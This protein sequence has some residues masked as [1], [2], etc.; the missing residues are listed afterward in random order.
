MIAAATR[1]RFSIGTTVSVQMGVTTCLLVNLPSVKFMALTRL[2]NVLVIVSLLACLFARVFVLRER[3]SIGRTRQVFLCAFGLL[4]Y[5][6]LLSGLIGARAVADWTEVGRILSLLVAVPVVLTAIRPSDVRVFLI[7]QAGWSVGVALWQMTYGFTVRGDIGLHYLNLGVGIAGGLVVLG[8][9]AIFDRRL[10]LRLLSVIGMLI[11]FGGLLRLYGRAP[12]FF[13]SFVVVLFAVASSVV[14]GS[15]LSRVARLAVVASIVTIGVVQGIGYLSKNWY[16]WRRIENALYAPQQEP[17]I[18]ILQRSFGVLM[19][20]PVFGSG[21]NAAE[22]VL[23]YYPHNIFLDVA[24]SA[25]L[26]ALAC[27]I[28]L[29]VILG[30]ATI[31]ALWGPVEVAAPAMLAVYY[32]MTWNVSFTI[33][34]SYV[35]FGAMAIVVAI[36]EHR[37]KEDRRIRIPVVKTVAVAS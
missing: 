11:C 4:I 20:R 19:E 30:R 37:K 21:L 14:R 25:G 34:N 29:L 32:F 10:S 5:F 16:G 1:K 24:I 9:A 18:E 2:L 35:L 23:G 36:F 17:R 12:I 27:L 6:L 3:I 13:S 22:T 31:A 33:G 7:A 26:P 8:G 15:S 28:V